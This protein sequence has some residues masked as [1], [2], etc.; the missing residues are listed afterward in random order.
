MKQ[1]I[2]VLMVDDEKRFRE[3]TRKIL[4]RNGFQTILAEN[5]T[6]ALKCLDQ[7]PDVAILDIRMPGMDGHEVLEKIIK[8][9]P[10]LP[11]IMLTGHGDK[12]SAEQSLVLGAFDY[13][14][15][16]CD[17]DLLSDKIREACRSK[18]QTGKVEEDPVGLAMIPLS[19]YTTIAE[20]ATIA[21]SIQEL[22]ASFVTLPTSDLIM[23][24]GHRSILV[25]DKNKQ[26]QGILTIRDL[27]E[28]I[29]PGY[30]TSTKPATADSIQ[31][32]PMFWQ[33]MFTSAVKQIGSLTISE[34]M[35]PIP[36]SIDAESTL[37]E[38]A[39]IMVDQNQRR[40]IVTENGKPTGVIREQDLFFQMGKHLIPPRIRSN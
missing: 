24:T 26:I 30:L 39:W 5:G 36:I 14:S 1:P 4:E 9:K 17:I 27:L 8:L 37:M 19:A 13:L 22:K 3:T 35:S 6:E 11:V 34:L 12:D 21:E 33:G 10:D 40:L 29:L 23:E 16:P 31:Y 25:M 20:D 15:K 28:R 7:S 32:S 18:Q 38:A 2:K